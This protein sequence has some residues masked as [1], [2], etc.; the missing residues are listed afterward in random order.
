LPE[1]AREDQPTPLPPKET[2]G[3]LLIAE[4]EQ[5]TAP[6]HV[7]FSAEGDCT[8]GQPVFTWDFGDGS[9]PAAGPVVTHT[10]EKPGKYRV[11][12]TVKSTADPTLDDRDSTEVTVLSA[13]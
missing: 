2:C 9:P 5:G 3:V 7:E 10:F 6:L 4:T 11:E 8:S 13:S 12:V 1:L